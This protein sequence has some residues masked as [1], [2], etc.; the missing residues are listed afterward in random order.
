MADPL[1]VEVPSADL[2]QALMQRLHAFPTELHEQEGQIEVSV[3]LVGNADRAIVEVLD[4]VDAW[5]AD[6][7]LQLVR[8]HL[9]DRVYT[10]TPPPAP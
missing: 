8:V 6:E 7:G 10:L 5:L 4:G 9:D 3:A 1:R 2:A